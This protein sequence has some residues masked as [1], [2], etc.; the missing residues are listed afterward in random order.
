[1]CNCKKV[2][3]DRLVVF[4]V[5]IHT[6]TILEATTLIVAACLPSIWPLIKMAFQHFHPS[7]KPLSEKKAPPTRLGLPDR[8]LIVASWAEAQYENDLESL[9]LP[10]SGATSIE[11]TPAVIPVETFPT[12]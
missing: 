8:S 1:M 3:A 10:P 4:A 2:P 12:H 7:S 9:S 11:N 6:W 5:S